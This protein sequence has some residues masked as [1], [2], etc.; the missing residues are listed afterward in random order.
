MYV[1]GWLA[2]GPNGVIAT[3]MFNAFQTAETIARDYLIARAASKGVSRAPSSTPE[4]PDLTRQGFGNE[5]VV[6]WEDWQAIDAEERRIGSRLG[7]EREKFV[8]VAD[9]LKVLG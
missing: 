5:K 4:L 1:C 2:R 6:S 3:T 8:T 9:M 7:K